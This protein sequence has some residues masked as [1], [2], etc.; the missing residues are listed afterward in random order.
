MAVALGP[1]RHL[2]IDN[3]DILPGSHCKAICH[4]VR[5]PIDGKEPPFQPLDGSFLVFKERH[6][7]PLGERAMVLS[8]T[9]SLCGPQ[10]AIPP[11]GYCRS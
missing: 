8:P 1:W 3:A 10:G 9:S 4:A 5:H 7:Q 11:V 6:G 2:P